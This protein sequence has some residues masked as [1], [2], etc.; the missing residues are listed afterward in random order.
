MSNLDTLE[1]ISAALGVAASIVGLVVSI[2]SARRTRQRYYDEFMA[3]R[4]ERDGKVG[5]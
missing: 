2:W 3:R 4:A 1:L 5:D